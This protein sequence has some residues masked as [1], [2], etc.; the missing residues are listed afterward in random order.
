MNGRIAA[1]AAGVAG[2]L[3]TV[4]TASAGVLRTPALVPEPGGWLACTITNLTAEPLD[5]DATL[6]SDTREIVTDFISTTWQDEAGFVP[7][8]FVLESMQPSAR[9]CH[10]AVSG[11]RRHDVMMVLEAFDAN[12]GRTGVVS[13]P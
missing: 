2:V 6:R 10:L 5:F 1:V 9:R 4:Q 3:L 7:D 13:V 8:T 12:G 11:G